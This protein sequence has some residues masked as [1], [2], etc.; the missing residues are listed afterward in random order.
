MHIETYMQISLKTNVPTDEG[1]RDTEQTM[2]L[3]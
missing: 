2:N 1:K 3:E